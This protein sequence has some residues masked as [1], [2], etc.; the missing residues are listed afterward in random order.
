M[1]RF[2]LHCQGQNS[3]VAARWRA[4]ACRCSCTYYRQDRARRTWVGYHRTESNAAP[5]TDRRK[6][7]L[8]A[9]SGRVCTL[10]EIR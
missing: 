6:G 3:H 8:P 7:F 5:F 9:R 2:A 4:L 10:G 1:C